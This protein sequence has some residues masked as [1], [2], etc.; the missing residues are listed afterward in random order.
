MTKD[1]KYAL[2]SAMTKLDEADSYLQDGLEGSVAYNLH[3]RIQ[4]LIDELEDLVLG[5]A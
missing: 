4:K 1:Q 3:T 2:E 5:N